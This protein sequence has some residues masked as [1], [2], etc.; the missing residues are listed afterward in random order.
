MAVA[1]SMVAVSM[2][3]GRR[4]PVHPGPLPPPLASRFTWGEIAVMRIV[5]CGSRSII[6]EA[7]IEHDEDSVRGR[8]GAATHPISP[9]C[10]GDTGPPPRRV[11]G[12]N[13]VSLDFVS[14][15]LP[16]PES[17]RRVAWPLERG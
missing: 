1:V 7:L 6:A 2:V 3:A 14:D 16:L 11:G 12:S 13:F 15:A 8:I 4:L 9:P 10:S 17:E 5:P